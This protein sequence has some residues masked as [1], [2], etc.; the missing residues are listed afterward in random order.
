MGNFFKNNEFKTDYKKRPHDEYKAAINKLD[1]ETRRKFDRRR[2]LILVIVVAAV[3]VM[4]MVLA[5]TGIGTNQA[6]S[7]GAVLDGAEK[8]R[9]ACL[10]DSVTKG[11][12]LGASG[13]E[14]CSVTYPDALKAELD[15]RLNI[16]A[17]VYNFGEAEGIAENTSY[18]KMQKEADLVI[19]Q[20]L[21]ENCK[22]GNDPEGILEA[23]IDGLSKQGCRV[24]L[25]NYPLASFAADSNAVNQ[26]NQYIAKAAKEKN[27]LLLDAAAHFKGLLD[28]GH[29]EEELFGTDG[30]HL[31]EKGYELLG[32]FVAGGLISDAGLE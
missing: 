9:I 32:R 28:Q 18:K 21:L 3:F 10:G 30:I 12:M 17:E 14:N 6:K 24:Y 25:L 2:A 11:L 5:I 19:L 1:E 29:T 13:E 20:Y 7:A 31:T 15:S 26:A 4:I 27:I 16:Q 8:A 23:N 22:T